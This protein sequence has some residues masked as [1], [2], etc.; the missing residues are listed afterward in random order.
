MRPTH[1]THLLAACALALSACQAHKATPTKP[2]PPAKMATT[3]Q[4]VAAAKPEKPQPKPREEAKPTPAKVPVDGEQADNDRTAKASATTPDA[5]QG[6]KKGTKERAKKDARNQLALKTIS[7]VAGGKSAGMGHGHIG[8]AGLALGGEG[9]GGG[10]ITG[11]A[12]VAPARVSRGAAVTGS[13]YR[14]AGY[15]DRDARAQNSEAYANYGVNQMTPTKKDAK[16]TFSIDVDT[17]S[18][19]IA[20]RKL[21]AGV[22]PP[23]SAVRVEE[24]V[25]YFRYDYPDP[26]SGPFGVYMEAAPSPF[27][28]AQDTKI[29]RI[30]VQGKRVTR[31]QRKPVHLTFLVDVSGSMMS[32]DKL[33]LAQKSLKILTNNLHKGDTVALATYAGRVAKIL[34]PTGINRRGRILNAIDSLQAG[35][36]TAMN[37]GLELAY[38]L[39]LAG[40]KR[41]EVNRVIVLS[42]GD[43]NV[44]P[45]S[46]QDI[47]KSIKHYV[48]EGVTLSTIGFGMGNYKDT[49]MEQLADKGNGNYY[50]ID[51][52]K[53]ARKVFGDQLDGTLQVIAKDVKIQVEFEPK[54]VKAY[55][56]IGYENRDI[57]DKDFRNDKVDAGEI[58]AGHTVTAL[59]EIEL[60]DGAD[61]KAANKLATVRIR[62]KKPAAAK[63]TEQAFVLTRADLHAKLRDASK[64]FQF[65][66]AVAGFAEILRGSKYAKNLSFDLIEEVAKGAT[67]AG[68]TDREE[69]LK[70]VK[71]AKGL[72]R[73]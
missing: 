26:D 33:G 11:H 21:N 56:L 8:T 29:L 15:V 48:D 2:A 71:K 9:R 22:L 20:R 38:K 73:G 13:S 69:F 19:T 64:D 47:L 70:L 36:S 53:E 4:P 12:Y 27:S 65:A 42:D 66:A 63:A 59:Y 30:G 44:G 52:K 18:Y 72:K 3:K 28:A 41:N 5:Q 40:F 34:D 49:M 10:G 54:T 62:H 58:G 32:P 14:G 24:F 57:A 51:T 37:D 50:Y 39:A 25:N 16:S 46:H 35:G 43:A 60:A 61:A 7:V 17:G 68:Q 1:A 67:A 55:R 6:A 31:S 45:H 23:K